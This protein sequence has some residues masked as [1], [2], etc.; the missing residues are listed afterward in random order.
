MRFALI[1]AH[2]REEDLAAVPGIEAIP[3][4]G[5]TLSAIA[6]DPAEGLADRKAIAT[7]ARVRGELLAIET[8]V[9][10]RYGT[11]VTGPAEA[12]EK[13]RQFLP[14][15]KELLEKHRGTVEMTLKV[16]GSDVPLRPDRKQFASGRAYLEEL[17]RSRSSTSVD[18][19]FR[20]AAEKELGEPATRWRWVRRDDGGLE[21]AFLTR[22]ERA[23]EVRAAG[24]RLKQTFP[25]VPFLVSGPWP[26]EVF[27]DGE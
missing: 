14:A 21:L 27:A 1:G 13:C 20:A 24:L 12:M 25:E 10:L 16:A 8:F 15:W 26:L 7:A 6:Y 4:E 19:L 23:S 3:L 11:S 17:H 5:L 9:A 2:L 18:P 22:R